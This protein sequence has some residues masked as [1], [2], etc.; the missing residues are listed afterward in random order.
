VVLSL[1]LSMAKAKRGIVQTKNPRTGRY[2]KIDTAKGRILNAKK[3]DGPYKGIPVM[4]KR[5]S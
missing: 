4:R 5:S 1:H 3:S 2:V